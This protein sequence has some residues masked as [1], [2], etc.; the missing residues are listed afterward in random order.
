MLEHVD[1]ELRWRP[2][3]LRVLENSVG[4]RQRFAQILRIVG[5]FETSFGSPTVLQESSDFLW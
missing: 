2:G 1:P 4:R 5:L 3:K